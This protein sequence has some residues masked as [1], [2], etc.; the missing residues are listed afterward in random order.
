V[1]SLANED[2]PHSDIAEGSLDTGH[3]S[4]HVAPA[5]PPTGVSGELPAELFPHGLDSP[6]PIP[7]DVSAATDLQLFGP[8]AGTA[9][10]DPLL[11]S[12]LSN[13]AFAAGARKAAGSAGARRGLF[14]ALVL[15]PLT[16]YSILA[17]LAVMVLYFRPPQ[18]TLEYLPDLEGEFRGA[19]HQQRAAIS[20]ERLDPDSPLPSRL[21]VGLGKRLR[22]GDLEVLPTGVELRRIKFVGDDGDEELADTDSL[23]LH[24]ALKNAS[25]DLIFSPTDPYF[26]RRWTQAE[27]N[28][29]YTLLEVGE[30]RIYGGPLPW[31]WGRPA[32]FER[33]V[34]GQVYKA[35]QPGEELKTLVCT[36]PADPVGSLLAHHPSLLTYRVQ[37]RRGLVRIADREIPATAVVGIQFSTA[38][39]QRPGT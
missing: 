10:I 27:E 20:Y 38:E 33:T 31:R 37:V 1:A 3:G 19:Q 26:D 28:K 14:V 22:V 35:L 16:S 7:G 8:Q 36:N 29:P 13:E 21:K 12:D 24:L 5:L 23:V 17:T 30:H 2:N 11:G 18:P 39:I 34:A 4:D 9:R 32:G 15:V 6:D 25:T